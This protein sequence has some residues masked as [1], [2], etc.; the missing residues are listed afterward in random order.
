M[1]IFEPGPFLGAQN[2]GYQIS[3]SLRFR[4]SASAYLSRT[5]A[6]AGNQQKWTWSGWVKR[7][8]L[9]SASP[10]FLLGSGTNGTNDTAFYFTTADK[11]DFYTRT[12]STIQGY[13]TTNAV[14]RDASAWY[15]VVV[16]YDAANATSTSRML[17]YVNNVLQAVTVNNTLPPSTNGFVNAAVA[18]YHGTAGLSNYLDGYLAEVNFIDGQALDPTSF[19]AYD[20]T[21]GVWGP[22]KYAGSYSGTNSFYLPFSTTPTSSYASSFNGSSQY[23]T[24]ATNAGLGLGTSDFTVEYWMN[25]SATTGSLIPLTAGNGTTTYDSLF[26]YITSSTMVLYMSSTGSSWDIASGRTIISSLSANTWYHIAITR[27]GSTFKT[28]VNG[29]QVDTF[30][31]SASIYQSANQFTIARAQSAQYYNGSLSNVRVVKGT[32]LYT[33]NFTPSVAPLT[34]VTN[35]QLLTLQS[36]TIVDNSSNALTITNSG[37]VTSTASTPW[38][39]LTAGI[40]SSGLNNNWSSANI[41]VTSSGTTYDSMIDSPTPYSDGTAYGRGNYATLNPLDVNSTYFVN[42]TFSNANLSISATSSGQYYVH[43]T[44]SNNTGKF[45][46][47]FTVT[48]LGA[49]GALTNSIVVSAPGN[50]G[51]VYCAYDKSGQKY[52]SGAWTTG[53]TAWST[54]DVIGIAVDYDA[55]SA[56]YYLNGTLQG[57]LTFGSQG[58]APLCVANN[59]QAGSGGTV[60]VSFN[61]GQRPF[62]ISSIPSGFLALNTQNLPTPTIANGAQYFDAATYSGTSAARSVTINNGLFTPDLVWIKNRS[63]A[64]NHTLQDINRSFGS[65]RGLNSNTTAAE[66]ADDNA[67][68]YI[69]AVGAGNVSV[70]KLGSLG[71]NDWKITNYSG[72]SYAL[73]AWK[74]GNG[75]SNIAVNAYGSTP[76]IASTVSANTSAGFSV[77]TYTGTG[78]NATVGHGLGVAPSLI[79]AK[80]RSVADNWLIYHASLGNTQYVDFTTVAAATASTAWNNTSPTSTVFSL[81]TAPRINTASSTNVAYCFAPVAGYS[82][83]FSFTGNGSSDGPMVFLNFRPR[84]LMIKRT[85]TTGNWVVFDTSRQTINYGTT[86]DPTLYPNLSIAEATG[87]IDILSNGFKVRYT[88][89]DYN[90]SNGTYIGYAIAE[91]PF[92]ISRAR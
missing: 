39:N 32:A 74:A 69:S 17:I 42:A 3:R 52:I 43:P 58:S 27:S 5:P 29:V 12:S 79:I 22:K 81:G 1:P 65:G 2:T 31:S 18:Q 64:F 26:G 41:N 24:T 45:Y 88:D 78:A 44:I 34:A 57:T 49:G 13:I 61:A 85:D 15:H 73:W 66:G 30:T 82:A 63:A 48:S 23:L 36:S 16:V 59:A 67:Y 50:F 86:S 92:R 89:S 55:G 72:D 62:S 68:G 80:S 60:S 83:A 90:A 37:S 6:S 77:V 47:E 84:W 28:F 91:N 4:S 7:G 46:Q 87:I 56:T 20:T 70:N 53:W 11:I 10:Q 25:S 51:A 75:T 14:F 8:S 21:T 33:A 9:T 19:G 76:S 54:N 38:S 71:A 40:D 35:T